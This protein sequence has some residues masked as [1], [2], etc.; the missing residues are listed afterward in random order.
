MLD[1]D[2]LIKIFTVVN[3]E[4]GDGNSIFNLIISTMENKSFF[5]WYLT[6]NDVYLRSMEDYLCPYIALSGKFIKN[7]VKA[8]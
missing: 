6:G 5:E 7:E 1:E 2:R 8:I 3:A 4:V